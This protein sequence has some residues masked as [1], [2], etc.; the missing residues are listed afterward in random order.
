MRHIQT[1]L[2]LFISIFSALGVTN[3]QSQRCCSSGIVRAYHYEDV[4]VQ[5]FPYAMSAVVTQVMAS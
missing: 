1:K 4:P 5:R 3:I 2:C